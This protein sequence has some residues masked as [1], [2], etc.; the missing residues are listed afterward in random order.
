M[1]PKDLGRRTT[2]SLSVLLMLTYVFLLLGLK[3]LIIFSLPESNSY[4]YNN[5]LTGSIPDIW[6]NMGQ[7]INFDLSQNNLSGPLPLSIAKM[8]TTKILYVLWLTDTTML[9]TWKL[10]SSFICFFLIKAMF[11]QMRWTELCLIS[12]LTGPQL[13]SSTS[14]R[15]SLPVDFPPA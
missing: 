5:G 1:H 2:S 15:I 4:F 9:G 3:T 10:T 14:A 8:T 12:G 13:P 7:M 6:A 11:T